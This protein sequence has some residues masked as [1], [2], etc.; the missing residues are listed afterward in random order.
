MVI[1]EAALELLRKG[2]SGSRVLVVGD[3]ILDQTYEG[4]TG[5]I[6]PEAPIP[7]VQVRSSSFGLGGA[8]NVAHNLARLGCPVE[9]AA[10]VGDDEEGTILADLVA[11]KGVGGGL[12]P[13]ADRP[14]TK[15]VRILSS[16]QQMLRLDFENERPLSPEE[17]ERLLKRVTGPF[18]DGFKGVVLSDYGKGVCTFRVC[19]GVIRECVDRGIPLIVDPKGTEWDKYRGASLVTPNLIELGEA[20][21]WKVPNEDDDIERA[22]RELMDRF[23]L[24]SIV[25]TRS[26]KGLSLLSADTTFHEPAR[27]LE[28]FDVTGAGDTVVA[29]LSAFISA[30]A[31]MKDAARMANL[32][33]G[34]V[35]G[36]VGTYAVGRGELLDAIVEDQPSGPSGKVKSV[37]DA[38]LV[39]EEW[40]KQGNRVVFTNG[41][42][43]IL[44]AGHVHCIEKAKEQGDR[45][46]VGLN[47]DRSVKMNKGPGRPLNPQEL[48]AKV[49]S[50]LAA[51]DMVVVFEEKTPLA[52][53]NALRPDVLAKGGDYRE[54]E[55]VGAREVASWGGKVVLV[56]LLEGLSTT[57]IF[58]KIVRP[59][60]EDIGD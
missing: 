12:I 3:P 21:G 24:G 5:R 47:S 42:F 49:L 32:A 22:A 31:S 15:K 44:H 16:R 60:V 39:A 13:S 11:S 18:L 55:V 29:V 53:I 4:S 56:P 34:Y 8:C 45:L 41:C 25:V 50:A 37:E 19:Q 2:F 33:A 1:H 6:S 27:A 58:G 57:K 48:R 10:V 26:E 36:K 59:K 17:E 9:L 40:K 43:D 52:L 23:S 20:R 30:G 46:V 28:V 7:V 35:V 38:A 14:T 51:V 54:K